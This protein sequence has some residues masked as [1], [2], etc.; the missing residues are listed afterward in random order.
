VPK[1]V[2]VGGLRLLLYENSLSLAFIVLFFMS[3]ALHAMGGAA[4]YSKEQQEHGGKPVSVVGYVET[5]QFWYESMQN[6]QSEYL[7]VACMV[8]FSVRLRQR[9][10]PESKPVDMPHGEMPSS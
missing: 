2:E 10:S 1:A 6:W 5:P 7:A 9:G 4:A 8:F 3:I